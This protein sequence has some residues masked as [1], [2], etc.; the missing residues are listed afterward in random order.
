MFR[1]AFFGNF[2][3]RFFFLNDAN[4]LTTRL[5]DIESQI[6]NNSRKDF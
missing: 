4:F 3:L 1:K 6:K 5:K 2:Y